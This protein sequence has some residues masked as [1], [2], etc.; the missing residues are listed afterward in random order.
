MSKESLVTEKHT[1]EELLHNNGYII[2]TAK[3]NSM[4]PLLRARRDI[5]EIRTFQSPPKKY[6]VVLYKRDGEPSKYILHRVIKVLPNGK[7]ILAGD[8]NI[9]KEYD[10]KDEEIIGIM[11]RVVRNGKS[12]YVSEP[13]YKLYSH[14]W[15]DF[16]PVRVV[17]LRGKSVVEIVIRRLKSHIFKERV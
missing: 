9:Y 10:V 5:I 11:T 17:I 6:D 12:V 7:Y 15:V 14:L 8:H 2:Y 16:F 1:F 13:L 4:L 3:G